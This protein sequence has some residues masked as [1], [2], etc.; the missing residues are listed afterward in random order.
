MVYVLSKDGQ[1]LMPTIR[2][3][4]VRRSLKT[5][6]AKVVNRCPFTIQLSYETEKGITQPV[7]VG[8]DAGSKHNGLSAAAVY[9]SGRKREVYSSEVQMRTD[10]TKLLS[11]RR[12]GR[13]T[14]RNRTT[15]YRQPRFDNRIRSKHKEWIAPS[16]EHKIQLHIREL[17][18]IR[19][20]L[21]V[22]KVTVEVAAF[23]LQKLKADLEGLKRPEG[24]EYQQGE[25]M[26]Y[27]NL[28]E[29]CFWRDNYTCQWC[30]GK[31]GDKVLHMH[32]WNYWRGD[33]SDKPSSVITLCHTCNDSK[34]HKQD[35]FLWG[36]KPKITRSYKD[37]TF[38]GIMRWTFY[39][40]LKEMYRLFGIEIKLTYGYI[41]K[42]ER[43]KHGLKKT[44]CTD[45]RVIS[46]HPDAGPLGYYFYKQKTR[47]HNRQIH[48]RKICKGNVRKLNQAPK[49]VFGYQIFDKVS[50]G[51]RECF[52]YG[53]RSSGSF[54]I[55]TLDGEKISAGISYK[56]LK[57]L[58]SRRSLLTERRPAEAGCDSSLTDMHR[59]GFPH[60]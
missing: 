41:T 42:N 9:P 7:E 25:L 11:E 16:V 15:R 58:E 57:L 14:R 35:G 46:G 22:T 2:H 44:H 32:H 13:R 37:A 48:K 47:C 28:R 10:I 38:M 34:N 50:C 39:N 43:I 29:Y 54:D 55:R 1:P 27:A 31:S 21:P 33:H 4:W 24:T 49:Y 26:N 5:G 36:W 8:D 30:K 53:R 17:D 56:K 51:D 60:T 45:A 18:Y 52:I 20:I 19:S 12:E 59:K 23:D 3:G 40:R 6:R